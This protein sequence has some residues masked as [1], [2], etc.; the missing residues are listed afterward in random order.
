M[1]KLLVM[2]VGGGGGGGGVQWIILHDSCKTSL[3]R[4][5]SLATNAW[6][7]R[8]ACRPELLL[9]MTNE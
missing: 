1:V 6:Q 4:T 9:Q 3:K 8:P 7:L 5:L 2:C